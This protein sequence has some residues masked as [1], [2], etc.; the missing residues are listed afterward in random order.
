[1]KYPLAVVNR[2]LDQYGTDI[3]LGY[4]IMCMFIKTLLRSSLCPK[5]LALHLQGVVPAFHGHAHNHSCQV[6]WHPMY[7]EGVGLKDF[8]E[9]ER[10]FYKSNK[11]ASITHLASPFHRQQQIDKHFFFHDIDKH[12]ASG[13]CSDP[14]LEHNMTSFFRQFYFPELLPGT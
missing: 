2:L 4:D 9:C 12:A 1:M 13:A 7:L 6:S 10:M 5:I 11:F 14:F 3:R 8:E